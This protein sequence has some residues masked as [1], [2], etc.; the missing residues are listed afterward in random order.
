[1]LLLRFYAVVAV[2]VTVLSQ[3]LTLREIKDKCNYCGS[4]HF[5]KP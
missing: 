2:M 1:M 3:S 5:K 4:K